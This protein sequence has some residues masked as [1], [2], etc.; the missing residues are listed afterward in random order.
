MIFDCKMTIFSWKMMNNDVLIE[1]F[2]LKND[3]LLMEN[4]NVFSGALRRADQQKVRAF[5]IYMKPSFNR[6]WRF[7]WWKM[8]ITTENEDFDDR[9]LM[10]CVTWWFAWQTWAKR[11]ALRA[12]QRAK[13][14]EFAG[15]RDEFIGFQMADYVL[16]MTNCVPKQNEEFS[17]FWKWLRRARV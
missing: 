1:D 4:D 10:V 16:K 11:V 6:K 14:A 3:D 2:R 12:E 13:L 7:W 15:K 17:V 9:K 5:Y 8:K